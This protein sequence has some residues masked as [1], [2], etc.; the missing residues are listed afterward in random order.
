MFFGFACWGLAGQLAFGKLGTEL[1]VRVF[2]AR[3]NQVLLFGHAFD[4]V[5]RDFARV[6]D[7][8]G[9][10]VFSNA[11]Q[12]LSHI[13]ST[14]PAIVRVHIVRPL[15]ESRFRLDCTYSQLTASVIGRVKKD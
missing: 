1:R 15:A 6:V 4:R 7:G 2:N 14:M 10:G 8:N 5:G 12:H 9:P 13:P 11:V 3:W